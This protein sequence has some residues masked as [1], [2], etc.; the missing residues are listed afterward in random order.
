[1]TK[2][3]TLIVTTEQH[4]QKVGNIIYVVGDEDIDFWQRYLKVF[5]EILVIGRVSCTTS[6]PP[7]SKISSGLGVRFLELTEFDGISGLI[8]NS[9]NLIKVISENVS[10]S[11]YVLLRV[12]GLLSYLT[13]LIL[14]FKRKKW[15]MEVVA[16]PQEE[17]SNADNWLARLFASV[18]VTMTRYMC[19]RASSV[20]YVTREVLQRR[21]PSNSSQNYFYSSLNITIDPKHFKNRKELIESQPDILTSPKLVLVGRMSKPFKGIDTA[22]NMLAYAKRKGVKPTLHL[23]G[24]GQLLSTYL[25]EAEKLGVN[26]Q[27]TFHG[28]ISDRSEVL[29]ILT[30]SDIMI[31]PSRREGLPRAI[32]EAMS[33]G[34]PVIAS[35]VAGIPELVPEELMINPN[36]HITLFDHVHKLSSNKDLRRNFSNYFFERSKPYD[37]QIL[38]NARTS[39]YKSILNAN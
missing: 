3:N 13:F 21:Y 27:C 31:L 35:N 25:K 30:Q 18:I 15:T 29:S 28:E 5:D 11:P 36:D 34:L 6:K 26:D 1:M 22:L 7:K 24:G 12:P 32:I 20:S 8:F 39:F 37:L 4:F 10:G 33:L 23:I 38:E 16:D 17:A 19:K 14:F 9:I 2:Q